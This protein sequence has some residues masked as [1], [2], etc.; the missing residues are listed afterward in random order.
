[1]GNNGI[2]DG[3]MGTARFSTDP[4]FFSLPTPPNTDRPNQNLPAVDLSKSGLPAIL[5]AG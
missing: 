5:L 4:N 3:I 2:M 1:M